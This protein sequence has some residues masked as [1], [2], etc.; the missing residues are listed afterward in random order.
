[1]LSFHLSPWLTMS[2]IHHHLC[3]ASHLV[4]FSD[5][6]EYFFYVM[7]SRTKRRW[8]NGWECEERR[9][10]ARRK[11]WKQREIERKKWMNDCV[12]FDHDFIYYPILDFKWILLLSWL[13]LYLSLVCVFT[14]IHKSLLGCCCHFHFHFHSHLTVCRVVVLLCT[15]ILFVVIVL[16]C[17]HII[18]FIW[19]SV[20]SWIMFSIFW[21]QYSE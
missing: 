9:K 8:R 5:L 20:K 10:K 21:L 15:V 14:I 2:D 17:Y 19:H 12:G 11:I 3:I 18:I 13:L 1:M 7:E 4:S 6:L 16:E